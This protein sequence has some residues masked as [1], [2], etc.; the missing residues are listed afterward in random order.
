L[1]IFFSAKA[2]PQNG[3]SFSADSLDKTSVQKLQNDLWFNEDKARHLAASFIASGVGT[4]TLKHIYNF[5][6]SKSVVI[7]VTFS[8]SLGL[9]KEVY[10]SRQENNHFSF[11]DLTADLVGSAIGYIVFK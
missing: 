4:L 8:F 6:K 3:F 5:K 1:L 11:K 9:V 2:F 10:D 7:G